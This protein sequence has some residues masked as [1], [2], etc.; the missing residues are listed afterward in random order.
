[1]KK[2]V[3]NF[4]DNRLFGGVGEWGLVLTAWAGG[5]GKGVSSRPEAPPLGPQNLPLIRPKSETMPN[6]LAL[7]EIIYSLEIFCELF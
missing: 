7:F 2:R 6:V 4:D 3:I 5:T 1:M